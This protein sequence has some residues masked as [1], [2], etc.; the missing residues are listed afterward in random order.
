MKAFIIR[1]GSGV[2]C[3]DERQGSCRRQSSV[4]APLS[5]VLP[6]FTLLGWITWLAERLCPSKRLSLSLKG[7]ST[8]CRFFILSYMYAP[9]PGCS[10]LR[11]FRLIGHP[12]ACSQ[13]NRNIPSQPHFVCSLPWGRGQFCCVRLHPGRWEQTA[14]PREG[15]KKMRVKPVDV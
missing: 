10:T 13:D 8:F 1:P 14:H 5:L 7:W 15:A 4:P 2:T 3:E 12:D 6:G 11:L 9:F